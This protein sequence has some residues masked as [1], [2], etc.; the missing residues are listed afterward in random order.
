MHKKICILLVVSILLGCAYDPNN[1]GFFPV[2]RAFKD[3]NI[4]PYTLVRNFAETKH[5]VEKNY[6]LGDHLVTN[7]GKPLINAK[8]YSVD[9]FY[10]KEIV[11]S[12]DI[13][14]RAKV[15][16]KKVTPKSN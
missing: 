2:K 10:T 16:G 1:H 6:T 3:R 14:I 13:E 9:Y 7:V 15:G 12:N 11:P 8:A 5:I 4:Q